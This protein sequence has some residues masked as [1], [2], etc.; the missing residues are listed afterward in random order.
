M[1]IILAD[2]HEQSRLA[3]ET[4]L[5][6]QP[7]FDLIGEAVDAQDLLQLAEKLTPNLFLLDGELPD[8]P[9]DELIVRLH[10]LEPRPIVIVMS[11]EV[12]SG[13]KMLKAGADVFVSKVDEPDWLLDKLQKYAKQFKLKE[14]ANRNQGP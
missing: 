14:A 11:G 9:V 13:R 1:R 10:A 12:E 7:E 3:L 8:M 2:H 6:E 4:L 5:E